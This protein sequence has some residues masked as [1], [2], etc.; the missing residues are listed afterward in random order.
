[1]IVAPKA[2]TTPPKAA[3][4]LVVE[5]ELMIRMLLEDMLDQLGYAVGAQAGAIEE[6]LSAVQN[7]EFDIALLDVNL[8]GKPIDPVAKALIARGTPVVFATGYGEHGLPAE[9]RDC[10][11]LRKPFQLDDL[12][13]TLKLAFSGEHLSERR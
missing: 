10:P 3:R 11:V 4:I 7:G 9:F 13:R 6:A 8:N 5:D 1:M 2:E 12:S